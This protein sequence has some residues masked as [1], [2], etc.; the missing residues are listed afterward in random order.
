[1][2]CW[3]SRPDPTQQLVATL[4]EAVTLLRGCG[5]SHWSTWLEENA[6]LIRDGN[7]RAVERLL[8]A[9]G[10]MGSLNDLYLCPENGHHIQPTQIAALNGHLR[11]LTSRAWDLAQKLKPPRRR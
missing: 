1:M 6:G 3:I 9:Y 4:Q 5:E 2:V 8:G 7:L 11:D 10:G